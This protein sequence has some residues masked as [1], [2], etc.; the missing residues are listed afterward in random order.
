MTDILTLIKRTPGRDAKGKPVIQETARMVFCSVRSVGLKEFYSAHATDM[1]P[2]IK[3]VLADY[4]DYEDET[5]VEHNDRRY[6]V[7]RT[8]RTGQEL[9][10]VAERAPVEDGDGNG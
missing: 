5:L 8:Y 9:E 10:L 6:R 1:H 3:F 7:L 4:L 2:E